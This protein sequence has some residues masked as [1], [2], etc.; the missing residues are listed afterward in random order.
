MITTQKK[1]VCTVQDEIKAK[2]PTISKSDRTANL[3]YQG[4]VKATSKKN[5]QLEFKFKS[6][7]KVRVVL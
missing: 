1:Q 4:R 7:N 6:D 2:R 5:I 3:N